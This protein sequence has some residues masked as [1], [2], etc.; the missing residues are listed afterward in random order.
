MN[1][2]LDLETLAAEW[3]HDAGPAVDMDALR[4]ELRRRNRST[5][6]VVAAEIVVTA[7]LV[8]WTVGA[9]PGPSRSPLLIAWMWTYWAVATSLAWWNRFGQIR[10][11]VVSP[12]AF[13]RVSLARARAKIR[14]VRIV[15]GLFA[16]QA[17]FVLA[18]GARVSGSGAGGSAVAFLVASGLGTAL[19]GW[20]Y[21][22]RARHQVSTY[23]AMCA[24][25]EEG[26]PKG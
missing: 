7:L 3:R 24:E 8:A 16:A 11:S 4:S 15:A 21:H 9:V 26:G 19:W 25:M 22:G 5:T 1:E 23:E 6:W 14:V 18:Y 10:R 20:W 12:A 2:P 17:V 13:A